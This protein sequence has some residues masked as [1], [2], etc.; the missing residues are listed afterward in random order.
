[1]GVRVLVRGANGGF[2]AEDVA[3]GE[4]IAGRVA[5]ALDSA[6][7]YEER[8]HVVSVLRRSLRPPR[9][10]QIPGVRLSSFFRPAA[11]HLEV[12]GDF[13][14]VHG[15]EDDWLV[16]LGDVCGKGAEAAMLTGL[17]RQ[18]IRT[19]AYFDRRPS[20]VLAALNAVLYEEQSDRFVTV[21]CARVRPG[22]RAGS[23]RVD[24][25]VGGHPPPIIVR[26]DGTVEEVDVAGRLSGVL[27][28]LDYEDVAV[29]L[30][31]DDTMVMFSD[32][33]YEARGRDGVYGLDRLQR[34]LRSFAGTG[35]EAI[36]QAV[37]Q[38]VVEHLSG[39]PHDDMTLLALTSRR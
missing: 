35:P 18:S 31:V 39:H 13:Y 11:E 14:D 38:D 37:E 2:P 3:L 26:G 24:L 27:P 30:G 23:L 12:S 17:T 9:L 29:E 15:S 33:I 8:A 6:R 28:D 36:V 5:M 1:V 21:V 34:L 20:G 7:L 32:G 19:A 4:E 22:A 16:V 25:A 10:P